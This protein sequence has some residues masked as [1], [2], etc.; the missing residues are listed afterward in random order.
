MNGRVS[1]TNNIL[2]QISTTQLRQK[3]CFASHYLA[4]LVLWVVFIG[5][6]SRC[7][8]AFRSSENGAIARLSNSRWDYF[9]VGYW[10]P[11]VVGWVVFWKPQKGVWWLRVKTTKVQ[12]LQ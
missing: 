5:F 3:S 9:C 8:A 7:W 4:K 10:A 2:R 1:S 11:F 12:P 6:L